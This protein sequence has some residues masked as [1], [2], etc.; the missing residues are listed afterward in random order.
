MIFSF[1]LKCQTGFG[2]VGLVGSHNREQL[3]IQV[4]VFQTGEE[5]E[6]RVHFDSVKTV[7]S[8]LLLLDYFILQLYL[9]DFDISV[10]VFGS[11]RIIYSCLST[12]HASRNEN[13]NNKG[14][15]RAN[16]YPL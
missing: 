14:T 12:I 6:R 10:L 7:C 13:I 8:H 5:S 16:I 3:R 9:L 11:L 15:R 2:G 4:F 1:L